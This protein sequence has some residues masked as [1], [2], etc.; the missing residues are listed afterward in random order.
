MSYS[1]AEGCVRDLAAY[2]LTER[3]RRPL[4]VAA[5][6]RDLKEFAE[7]VRRGHEEHPDEFPDT[8]LRAVKSTQV[9]RY[10]AYMFDSRNY[11]SRSVCRKLSPINALFRYLYITGD[12]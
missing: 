7:F 11:D 3:S 9:R 4:T 1:E 5:Y 12:V 6:D 10:I 8:S 2:L